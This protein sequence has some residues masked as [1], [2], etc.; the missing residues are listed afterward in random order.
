MH[1]F[2]SGR[3][4]LPT[5][6]WK[7]CGGKEG[8]SHFF[9][10]ILFS[11]VGLLAKIKCSM[12]DTLPQCLHFLTTCILNLDMFEF[13]FFCMNKCYVFK[14]LLFAYTQNSWKYENLIIIRNM[15]DKT[16]M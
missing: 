10:L 8:G 15:P 12:R 4:V 3:T 16:V 14:A 6:G 5:F 13:F 2:F 1:T 11:I 9:Y 7:D